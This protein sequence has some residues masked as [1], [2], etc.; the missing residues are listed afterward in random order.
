MRGSPATP[1]VGYRQN[2]ECCQ[3]RQREWLHALQRRVLIKQSNT[4]RSPKITTCPGAVCSWY[5]RI[6][7]TQPK[8]ADDLSMLARLST[9]TYTL[10]IHPSSAC[11]YN[12]AFR[13]SYISMKP[14]T[15]LS[16]GGRSILQP[17]A[18]SQA[19]ADGRCVRGERHRDADYR[20]SVRPM[21]RS[22]GSQVH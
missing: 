1:A 10:S 15:R 21:G 13:S 18:S 7:W 2:V 14:S 4:T 19:Y 20:P 9:C 8:Q 22:F 5:L 12:T 6:F 17:L 16:A 11:A 3:A